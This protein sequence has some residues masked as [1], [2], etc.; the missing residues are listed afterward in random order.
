MTP[1]TN[2][3]N[4]EAE[5]RVRFTG[6]AACPAGCAPNPLAREE[7]PGR[8]A[9]TS[10]P[11]AASAPA[12]PGPSLAPT[13]PSPYTRPLTSM[14]TRSFLGAYSKHKTCFNHSSLTGTITRGL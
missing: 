3:G 2:P 8:A 1:V 12:Q 11:R 7:P 5:G 14:H 4:S 6:E 13:P 9:L 10:V